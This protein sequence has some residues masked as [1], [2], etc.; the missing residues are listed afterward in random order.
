MSVPHAF[1]AFAFIATFLCFPAAG[2][3]AAAPASAGA[4]LLL[5]GDTLVAAWIPDTKQAPPV[6][7]IM[8]NRD[9]A[10]VPDIFVI[11]VGSSVRFPNEDPFFHSI[12]AANSPDD[13]DIGFCGTGP[14]K[15]V[16]FLRPENGD[17]ALRAGVGERRVGGS[18]ALAREKVRSRRTTRNL[19]PPSNRPSRRRDA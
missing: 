18:H 4:T 6:D 16:R 1:R 3:A 15:I 5:H 14:G 17:I 10:F 11:P 19:G 13:F 12:Y 7:A 9:K 2:S 8:R